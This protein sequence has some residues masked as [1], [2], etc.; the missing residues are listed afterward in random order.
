MGTEVVSGAA[1]S[2][3]CQVLANKA[4]GRK[5]YDGIISS[6][7]IGGVT[8]GVSSGASAGLSQITSTEITNQGTRLVTT[9]ASG[10]LVSATT[11]GFG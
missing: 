3:G 11:G 9:T 2:A 10:A 8:G 1:A 4:D 6:A 5:F 7:L